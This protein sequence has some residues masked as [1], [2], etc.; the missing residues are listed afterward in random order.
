MN[1]KE[2]QSK[3]KDCRLCAGCQNHTKVFGAGDVKA[4]I[5]IVG[6][7]PGKDEVAKLTPFVGASGILLDKILSAITLNRRDLYFTNAILCRTGDDNR[8]PTKEEYTNCRKR[9]FEELMIIRPR[10]TLMVGSIALKTIMGDEYTVGNS[11]GQ[12]FTNFDKPCFFYF[13]IYH[14][15]WILH[16][17]TPGEA[18]AKK[19]TMWE[20]VKK[21]RADM[22][23]FNSILNWDTINYEIKEMCKMRKTQEI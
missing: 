12:W 21:L 8:T 14:P 18:A 3:H 6:E 5:A 2:F 22:D 15:S 10:Y 23:N 16:A 20:D 13:S 4:K 1:I 7:G 17:V 9:L 11:H 19:K